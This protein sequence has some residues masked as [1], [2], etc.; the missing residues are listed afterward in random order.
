[1]VINVRKAGETTVLDLN[2]R[3]ILGEPVNTFHL[4]VR[5]VLDSGSK[6]LAVNMAGVAYMDSSGVGA[7][8]AAYASAKKAGAKCKFFATPD[9]VR[10]ILKMFRLDTA[11]DL[12]SDEASALSSS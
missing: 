8:A 11:L 6:N 5:E 1:M 12:V 10:T 2:G 4:R 9:R 3:L 7:M